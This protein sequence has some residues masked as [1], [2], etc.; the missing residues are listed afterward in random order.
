MTPGEFAAAIAG[1][2]GFNHADRVRHLAFYLH[3][4]EKVDTFVVAD[5][6]R[7][8]AALHVPEPASG[9]STFLRAMYGRRPPEII[10]VRERFKLAANLRAGIRSKLPA[11][12][13][14]TVEIEKALMELPGLLSDFAEREY[15]EEALT[16]YRHGAN[17]GAIV[18]TWNLA[19]ARLCN[20]V[21]NS[22]LAEFNAATT[23]R[24]QGKKRPDPIIKRDD[25]GEMREYDVLAVCRTGGITTKNFSDVLEEKLKGRNR[26]AHPTQVVIDRITAEG[27]INELV[28]NVILHLP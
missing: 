3:E 12:R 20:F 22:K 7:L 14:K 17:R 28:K 16:C 11:A 10:R 23:V 18:M 1:F 15:L 24:F 13:T 26:A 9:V 2:D 27:Y 21:F 19:Y 6:R 8:Y 5:I 25:F 4:F